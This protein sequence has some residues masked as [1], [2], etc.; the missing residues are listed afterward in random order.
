MG[1]GGA[2]KIRPGAGFAERGAAR[3]DARA[4]GIPTCLGLPEQVESE[5]DVYDRRYREGT[6][7]ARFATGERVLEG[8]WSALTEA[9]ARAALAHSSADFVTLL[10]FGY[11]TGRVSQDFA[12]AYPFLFPATRQGLK[13]LAY[14]VSGEGLR[15]SALKLER[16]EGFEKVGPFRWGDARS[17]G[18]VAGEMIKRV[19]GVDIAFCF[20]H[21]NEADP[22]GVVKELLLGANGGRPLMV[23]S[24]WFG[25]VGHIP[26]REQR[27]AWF[28]MFGEV[29]SAAGEVAIS[30][31]TPHD[32]PPGAVSWE[33][34]FERGDLA[35]QPLLRDPG[36]VVYVAE[37]G[38]PNYYHLFEPVEVLDL[39]SLTAPTA[40]PNQRLWVE[41]TCGVN[42]DLLFAGVV[43]PDID[44]EVSLHVI[45]WCD[46]RISNARQRVAG[47]SLPRDDGRTQRPV[48]V[49][50]RRS[51][52]SNS[53]DLS[54]L[55]GF[56]FPR[57]NDRALARSRSTL[58]ADFYAT[59]N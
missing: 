45:D 51:S 1:D 57:S 26:G 53:D 23:T 28:S 54:D 42:P 17:G 24:S 22:P 5:T 31:S 56:T 59:A 21:G 50:G 37:N 58:H 33:D 41:R 35:E 15:Q 38:W 27:E 13:V 47:T 4:R 12:L 18:Y 43:D 3:R 2:R 36:D 48:L 34:A 14:D 20:V 55:G 52:R 29:T 10:D 40:L 6:Y 11:G 32:R 25:S 8:E 19:N 39:M 16:D 30:V 46:T 7:D 9:V 44:G 49:C